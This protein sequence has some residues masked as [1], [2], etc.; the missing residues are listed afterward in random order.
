MAG[1][2]LAAEGARMTSNEPSPPRWV[3]AMLRSLLR[4]ADR[5]SISGDLL[6]EY[7][8]VRRPA[9]GALRANAWYIK[10]AFSMLWHLIRPYALALVG[11][12][13]VLALTVF[14]PGHHAVHHPPVTRPMLV[15]LMVRGLW[16]GS[17]TGAP[18]ASLLDA[19][20]Y[21]WAGC[22]GFQ[23][24]RLITAGILAAAATSFVGMTVLFAA[25][26]MITPD[27]LLA[28]F[29]N[30]LL[31]LIVSVYLLVPLGYAVVLG[32]LAGVVGRWL[33]PST[34]IR[35]LNLNSVHF[36]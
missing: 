9:L 2:H 13:I 33:P 3:E 1:A 23:R 36:G 14:R 34:L 27:L 6:E 4:P 10:H 24:T 19:L 22:H 26:A 28:V 20:I 8:V 17:I 29:V 15:S 18:G 32:A 7:R 30:P 5:E 31:L 21:F 11:P 12:S 16:Y 35:R 25:A